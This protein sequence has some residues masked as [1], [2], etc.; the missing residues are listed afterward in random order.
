MSGSDERAGSEAVRAAVGDVQAVE[1]EVVALLDGLHVWVADVQ[2]V[3]KESIV[4]TCTTVL[5]SQ[6]E[7][8]TS[9]GES[10]HRLFRVA[11]S[12]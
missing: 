8:L 12:Q 3:W 9:K 4:S 1:L 10:W 6:G 2:A 5:S 11:S 7:R